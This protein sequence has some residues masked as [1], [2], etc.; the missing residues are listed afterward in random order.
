VSGTTA[1][2]SAGS[3]VDVEA[4]LR[5]AAAE[6]RRSYP[7]ACFSSC[8]QSPAFGFDGADFVNVSVALPVPAG[9]DVLALNRDL[10]RIEGLCGRLPGAPRWAPRTMDLDILLFG[11]QVGEVGGLTLPRPS[12]LEWAFML[13]PTAELAPDL[14]HPLTGRSLAS[15]WAAFDRSVTPLTRLD[16]D[17]SRG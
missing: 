5:R 9:V 7:G 1:Y 2:V 11:D 3:N 8:W 16:L 17:L 10:E 6:L 12:L 14:V 15:H 13:G 4:N